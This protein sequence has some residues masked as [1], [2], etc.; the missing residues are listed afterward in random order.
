MDELTTIIGDYRSFLQHIIAEVQQAGF[1]MTDFVQLDH[2]CY[3]TASLEQ[4]QT[5]K[6]KL[7]S[8]AQ[9]LGEVEVNKRPIA[10][11]RLNTP[12]YYEG[13]RIDSIEIPAPKPGV[14]TDEGLEHI[15]FVL[16]DG[17]ETFL[18]KYASKSFDLKAA[19]RGI[20]PEVTFVLPTYKVKFHLLN[21]PTVVY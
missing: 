14:E 18:Q 9:L 21:L 2:M 6:E 10:V 19:G 11:L 7:T 17:Q 8:V 12:I 20:N 5:K 1:E 16:Y 3:R 4:Y 15:E 13:W